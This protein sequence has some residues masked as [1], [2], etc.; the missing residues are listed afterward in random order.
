MRTT[1]L[2]TVALLGL[3]AVPVLAQTTMTTTQ[4]P[5]SPNSAQ[6]GSQPDGSLPRSAE[7]SEYRAAGSQLEGRSVARPR[8]PRQTAANPNAAPR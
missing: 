4:S 2:T 3:A 5:P 7:T 6:A 8:P 1:L